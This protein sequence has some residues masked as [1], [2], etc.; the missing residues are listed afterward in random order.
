MTRLFFF[1]RK[2]GPRL[3]EGKNGKIPTPPEFEF[4]SLGVKTSI[5]MMSTYATYSAT[6]TPPK[7]NT[8]LFTVSN[9]S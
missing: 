5:S 7:P 9:L 4:E 2:S 3:R 1:H 6:V 8:I